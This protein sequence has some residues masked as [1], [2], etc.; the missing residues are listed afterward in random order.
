MA[1]VT[2]GAQS[3]ISL[4]Q[5][6]PTQVSLSQAAASAEIGE[7]DARTLQLMLYREIGIAAV[8]AALAVSR[9]DDQPRLSPSATHEMATNLLAND[10]AA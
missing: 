9:E 6:S 2:D 8:A 1:E 4:S 7:M 10:K 3:H 5:V